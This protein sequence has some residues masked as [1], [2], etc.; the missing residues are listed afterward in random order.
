MCTSMHNTVMAVVRSDD[1]PKG[2]KLTTQTQIQER[3]SKELQGLNSRQMLRDYCFTVWH[4]SS[5]FF[6]DTIPILCAILHQ[7]G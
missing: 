3:Q 1:S 4:N 2:K 6:G 5:V 7:L